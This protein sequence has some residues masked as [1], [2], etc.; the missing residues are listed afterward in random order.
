ML[1]V[2]NDGQVLYIFYC[3][4]YKA[5]RPIL[6]NEYF[7]CMHQLNNNLVSAVSQQLFIE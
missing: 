2:D 7:W 3:L 4:T 1:N 5:T 6:C